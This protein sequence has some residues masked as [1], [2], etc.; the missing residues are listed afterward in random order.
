MEDWRILEFHH[1]MSKKRRDI[2]KEEISSAEID[3]YLR[4]AKVEIF[5]SPPVK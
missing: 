2:L 1:T 3:P 5:G 4:I